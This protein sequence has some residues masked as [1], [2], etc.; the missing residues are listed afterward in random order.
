MNIPKLNYFWQYP[1]YW[2]EVDPNFPSIRYDKNVI[3]TANEFN[4]KSDKLAKAFLDMG[5]KKG[6]VVL[7]VLPTVPEYILTFIAASKIGAIT[8]PMD[9]EYKKADFKL[10]IPHSNPKI[11]V[12]IDKWQKNHIADN[13]KE[14]SSE[15]GKIQYIIIGKH[16]LGIPFKDAISREYK[17][18]DEAL[19]NAKKNQDPKDCIL[20]VW[21]GGTTG[22]PKA[23]ELTHR[24]VIEMCY[25]ESQEITKWLEVLIEKKFYRSPWLV[26]LPVSHVGGALELIGTG[27][28]NGNEMILQASWSPW[29][30]LKAIQKYNLQFMGGVPTMFK[31]FLSLPDL[32]SYAP[33]K[34]LKLVVMS[35]EKTPKE[36]LNGTKEKICEKIVIGYGSTEAGSEVTFTEPG[37][38]FNKIANGYVGKPLPEMDIKIINQDGKKSSSG[39]IGEIIVKGPLT[40]KSYYNMPEENKAGFTSDGYCKTGDLG[41]LDNEGGLYITGRIKEIIRVGAYTVLP[42]EIEELVTPHPK[43]AIAAAL[44]APDDRRGEVVWLVIGP[45]LGVNFEDEDKKEILDICNQNLAKFKVPQKIIIYPLDPNDLPITRI[46]KVDKVRL[47]KEILNS[48]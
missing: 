9:K 2:A 3:I 36:V 20:V 15:F 4:E 8:I 14:L 48:P 47:K 43:V 1:E 5:V 26:N 16:D 32:E 27:I 37:D 38:D 35:G 41:Y 22:A 25:R 18:D 21:T 30:T 39:K 46:G 6:E 17:I 23:V 44:G 11:I 13:L 28:I 45:E 19:L 10:L 40:S 34:Y 33:K 42:A 24:N 31:I 12:T 7:T 29:E